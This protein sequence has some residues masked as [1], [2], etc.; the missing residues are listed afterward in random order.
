[1]NTAKAEQ[2]V[3]TQTT[4]LHTH[5]KN[6]LKPKIKRSTAKQFDKYVR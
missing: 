3:T 2:M 6:Q 1:M 4:T 5:S